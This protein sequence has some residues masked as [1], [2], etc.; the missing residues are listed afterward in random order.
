MNI[1]FI[2]IGKTKLSW[3]IDGMAE[4]EKRIARYSG[5]KRI[6]LPNLKHR[7]KLSEPEIC[8]EEGQHLLKASTGHLIL[9]DV[10]GKKISSEGLAEFIIKMENQNRRQLDFVIGGAYGFSEE[11]LNKSA[12]RISLSAMTFSHQI[13]RL[14]FLEQLYRAFSINAGEPYHHG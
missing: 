7:S 1:H 12:E 4:Y 11:V 9:L 13:I 2:G 8:K 5:Y 10:S 6:E 14:V 3:L